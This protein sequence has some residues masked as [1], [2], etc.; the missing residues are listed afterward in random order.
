[1]NG[2]TK[3]V[4]LLDRSWK[5]ISDGK[6]IAVVNGPGVIGLQPIIEPGESFSYTSGTVIED[7]IGAMLGSYTFKSLSGDLFEV[8]IPK[9]DLV[10]EGALN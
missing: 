2:S 5:V 9:F 6:T 7:P 3:T 10:F 1:M 4:Q 8:E